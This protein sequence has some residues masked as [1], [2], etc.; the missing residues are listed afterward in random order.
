MNAKDWSLAMSKLC[1]TLPLFAAIVL[2]SL[3]AAAASIDELFEQP[4]VSQIKISPTGD[5][6]AIKVFEDGVHSLVFVD[7]ESRDIVGSLKFGGSNEVGNFYWANQERVVAEVYEVGYTQEAPKYYGE[8]YAINYDG[9]KAELIFGYRSGDAGTGRILA[10]GRPGE[11][12]TGT[13]VKRKTADYAWARMIDPF[14]GDDREILISSTSMSESHGKRPV[15]IM[16]DIYSGVEKERLHASKFPDGRF[17]TDSQGEIRLVTSLDDENNIHVEGLPA[18]AQD[19]IE[20]PEPNFGS[21]FTPI[22]ISDDQK[23]AYVL[24]NINSDKVG[25]YELSLDGKEYKQ[26]YVNDDVDITSVNTSSDGR[27]VYAMR[28]DKNYPSYL[29]FS[30]AHEEAQIF[31]SMLATFPGQTVDI[32]SRSR[33]GQ[34]WIVHAS[35]DVDPGSF[36]LFD[37]EKNTLS[38]IYKSLPNIDSN[39]LAVVKPIEF[40]SFDGLKITGYFTPARISGD[41]VAPL[42]V[43]VHGGPRSRDYW[44]FDPEVQALATQGF[45]VLQVNYRGSEGFG[46]SFMRAGNL[47][48]GDA[49]QQDII[50]GTRWAIANGK[51]DKGKVCMMGASFGAYSAVQSAVLEPDLY[52]CVVA[53]AGIYDLELLYKRGEIEEKYWG[54]A[55]LEEVIGRD[56]EQLRKFSPVNNIA[57]LKS[58]IF[59]AHG[60]QDNIAPYEHAIHLR[61]EL[62]KNHK[63]Y[64]WFVKSSEAHGFYDTKNQVEYMKAVIAFLNKHLYH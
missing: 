42:V 6:L 29:V 46:E 16:L 5:Y 58:P 25:V 45:S 62:K 33:D 60:K 57:A 10:F 53:N 63:Q 9:T 28:I 51:A 15:A 1:K 41:A 17:Y 40:D 30:S 31:K 39:D 43:L 38:L 37:K 24:D 23:S 11:A 14:P 47:H 7:R 21:Y 2:V 22:A 27:S 61:Q 56:E 59:V 18:G 13:I 50:A 64:E 8:L 49:V 12:R 4:K 19:W 26:V 3:P 36:Y 44:Q 52:A 20:F 48:W 54:D 34:F 35:S 55:Y 32:T